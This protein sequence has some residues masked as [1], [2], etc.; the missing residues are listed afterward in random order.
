MFSIHG[1]NSRP[2]EITYALRLELAVDKRTSES[3]E[4]LFG[5]SMAAGLA[6]LSFVILI[7]LHSLTI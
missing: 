1:M 2:K 3:S 5:V 7:G 6:V 4:E